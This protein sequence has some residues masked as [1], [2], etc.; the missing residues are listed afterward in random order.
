MT[1]EEIISDLKH[2]IGHCNDLYDP[3]KL[4]VETIYQYARKMCDKQREGCL[5][6]WA[7]SDRPKDAIAIGDAP[8]PKEL[9]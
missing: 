9:L 5:V 3:Y 6:S 2:N 4:A 1:P 7:N 8:Y